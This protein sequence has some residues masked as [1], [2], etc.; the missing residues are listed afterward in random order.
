MDFNTTIQELEHE[1]ELIDLAII[2]VQNARDNRA[3]RTVSRGHNVA[4]KIPGKRRLTAAAKLRISQSMKAR[5]EARK[6]G[7]KLTVVR[8]KKAA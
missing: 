8:G 1:R 4:T 6:A 2:A 7:K 5:W 3:S